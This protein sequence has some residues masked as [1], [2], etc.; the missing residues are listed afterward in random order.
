MNI[1]SHRPTNGARDCS[2]HGYFSCDGRERNKVG[3]LFDTIT[4]QV[5]KKKTNIRMQ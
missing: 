1:I 3:K 2:C 4:L 5:Y